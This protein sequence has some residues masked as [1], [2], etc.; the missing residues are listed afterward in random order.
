MADKDDKMNWIKKHGILALL[1]ILV[2]IFIAVLMI[3]IIIT[4]HENN[5]IKKKIQKIKGNKQD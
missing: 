5:R 3:F 2:V 1:I 4:I